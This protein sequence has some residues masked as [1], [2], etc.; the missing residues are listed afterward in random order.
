VRRLGCSWS[1]PPHTSIYLFFQR[2]PKGRI[3]STALGIYA[4][5]EMSVYSNAAPS[6]GAA[7]SAR[8]Q[9]SVLYPRMASYP[10]AV[11][12]PRPCTCPPQ[13]PSITQNLEMCVVRRQKDT[14]LSFK[15]IDWRWTTHIDS[16]DQISL[17]QPR[18]LFGA[19]IPVSSALP[20]HRSDPLR[21]AASVSFTFSGAEGDHMRRQVK[22]FA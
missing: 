7:N 22:F 12:E 8:I 16:P 10:V 13:Q 6:V 21:S 14:S 20:H 17:Q 2:S 1:R 3:S 18:S 15:S 5:L 11:G 19:E 4:L 9:L